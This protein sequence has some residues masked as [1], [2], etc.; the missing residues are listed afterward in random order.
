M[1][2]FILTEDELKICGMV[3]ESRYSFMMNNSPTEKPK[4]VFLSEEARAKFSSGPRGDEE[5]ILCGLV[6]KVDHGLTGLSC[7]IRRA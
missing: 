6:V 5:M 3:D 1:G 7:Y 4:S 2:P